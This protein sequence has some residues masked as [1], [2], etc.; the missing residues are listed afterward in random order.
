MLRTSDS[1]FRE[2]LA[3]CRRS[4]K[5]EVD[6]D[7]NAYRWLTVFIKLMTHSFRHITSD[8]AY[9][10]PVI[11]ASRVKTAELLNQLLDFSQVYLNMSETYYQITKNRAEFLL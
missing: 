8:I 1:Y 7:T 3:A 5:L 9:I 10:A 2:D 11:K 4:R 6:L